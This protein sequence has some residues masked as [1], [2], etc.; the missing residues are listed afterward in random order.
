LNGQ[1]GTISPAIK[2]KKIEF[3]VYLNENNH[4]KLKPNM[5]LPLKVVVDRADSVL[6]VKYSPSLQ[7]STDIYKVE[8][9]VAIK[10]HISTG[11][12]GDS[13]LEIHSGILQGDQVII[14]DVSLFRNKEQV[15]IY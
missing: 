10:Q 2:D 3:D 9:S 6:R 13:Y 12:R 8:G 14:S 15:D 4:W 7:R 1:V 5:T 11:L